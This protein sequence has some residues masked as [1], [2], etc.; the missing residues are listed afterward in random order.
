MSTTIDLTGQR[1]GRLS[2]LNRGEGMISGYAA[3][4]VKCECGTVKEVSSRALRTGTKSCGC[5]RGFRDVQAIDI[6]GQRFGSL[7]V[8]R[9]DGSRRGGA[10]W[11][12][13]CDCGGERS[14]TGPD[15]RANRVTNCGCMRRR[16]TGNK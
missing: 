8:V 12:C 7:T 16:N 6:R 9:R 1:F 3:W 14:A 4:L 10:L 11:L 2:V 13:R 15:L 5:R